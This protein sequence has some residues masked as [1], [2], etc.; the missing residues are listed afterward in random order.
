M[1]H[2]PIAITIIFS[3]MVLLTGCGGSDIQPIHG[4]ITLNGNPIGPGDIL[5]IPDSSKGTKGK[6]ATGSFE[7][8]GVYTLTTYNKGDGALVGHHR[9][10][11]RP[12]APGAKPGEEFFGNPR[13]LAPIAP[14][15]GI[16]SQT[17]L[18]A[19][20]IAGED[21]IDFDLDIR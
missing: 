17:P 2:Y 6:G 14:K 8:D 7:A 20:V 11:I 15:Y 9:V 18:K 5:F 19:E 16:N 10:V 21:Q 1:P 13:T 12:R 4:K 3:L